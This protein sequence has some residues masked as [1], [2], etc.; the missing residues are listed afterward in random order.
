MLGVLIAGPWRGPL[1]YL[2]GGPLD[3][4]VPVKVPLGRRDAFGVVTGPCAESPVGKI[5]SI[6]KV[7]GDPLPKDL[8]YLVGWSFKWLGVPM[9]KTLELVAPRWFYQ[10]K[11]VVS[12][13]LP[14]LEIREDRKLQME[15]VLS[16]SDHDRICE[17]ARM[18]APNLLALFPQ[19]QSA[20]LYGEILRG[21]GLRVLEWP[22][23]VSAQRKAYQKVLSGDVDVLVGSH[24]A[25]FLPLPPG[26]RVFLDDESSDAWVPVSYPTFS[27]RAMVVERCRVAG[28]Q[29]ALGSRFPS[30]KVFLRCA[31]R[32]EGDLTAARRV[33]LVKPNRSSGVGGLLSYTL[34]N[35][36]RRVLGAGGAALWILDRKG[37]A[38]YLVCLDCGEDIR[39]TACGTPMGLDADSGVVRCPSCKDRRKSPERCPVCG[40]PFFEMGRVGLQA[41][42]D[43][44]QR[45]FRDYRILYVDGDMPQSSLKDLIRRVEPPF[46]AIGTRSVL[47][48]CDLWDVKLAAWLEADAEGFS[49]AGYDR[50]FRALAIMWE[51]LWRGKSP[52]GRTLLV[53]TLRPARGW[54]RFLRSGWR[55]FWEWEIKERL[56][57]RMPPFSK[58]VKIKVDLSSLE[59]SRVALERLESSG[60]VIGF[61]EDPEGF[62]VTLS[63]DADVET[64]LSLLPPPARL[65][66]KLPAVWVFND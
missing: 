30:S 28:V 18:F 23:S 54:R 17:V 64:V 47:S 31:K 29:L 39:C 24:G 58:V 7:L 59:A 14:S 8:W 13:S 21:E 63:R 16:P 11:P 3:E 66:S 15:H 46:L 61:D 35:N 42:L 62:M 41:V 51:S 44:A 57:L 34:I 1:S 12:L 45:R 6:S 43:E 4:G 52:E 33:V 60:G 38:G 32:P 55:R 27:I 19:R 53:Q 48:L 22:A 36:T 37:Y 20:A 9:G 40:G 2:W 56:A 25:A 49:K 50:D 26:W 65:T 10:E 5:R